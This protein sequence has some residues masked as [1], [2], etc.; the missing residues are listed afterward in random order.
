ME[1]I[2]NCH[3]H[4]PLVCVNCRG[5]DL[6]DYSLDIPSDVYILYHYWSTLEQDPSSNLSRF[7]PTLQDFKQLVYNLIRLMVRW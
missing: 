6:A 7:Y 3:C 2:V 5:R 1:Y 4:Q